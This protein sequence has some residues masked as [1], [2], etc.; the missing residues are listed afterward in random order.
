[1]PNPRSDRSPQ[2]ELSALW[3]TVIGTLKTFLDGHADTE[4]AQSDSDDASNAANVWLESFVRGHATGQDRSALLL[5]SLVR[6][7]VASGRQSARS[8][9]AANLLDRLDGDRRT[10]EDFV[11][12]SRLYEILD[13]SNRKIDAD[14]T[15]L[16]WE[17]AGRL[18][19]GSFAVAQAALLWE[20]QDARQ[21]A[22]CLQTAVA[23]YASFW[24]GREVIVDASQAKL[25]SWSVTGT[26]AWEEAQ[27]LVSQMT[28][29]ETEENDAVAVGRAMVY[30]GLGWLLDALPVPSDADRRQTSVV[31]AYGVRDAALA[32]LQL[33]RC[34]WS[35][36]EGVLF[37]DPVSLGLRLL[38][39]DWRRSF[40]RARTAGIDH[41]PK[42]RSAASGD[43]AWRLV[44]ATIPPLDERP[45]S[46]SLPPGDPRDVPLLAGPS[47]S[48]AAAL[49]LAALANGRP[50]DAGV[51]LTADVQKSGELF[52]VGGLSQ[53]LNGENWVRLRQS[54]PVQTVLVG[55]KNQELGENEV[56]ERD[57]WQTFG[58][59]AGLRVRF[60][61]LLSEVIDEACGRLEAVLTFLRGL[62]HNGLSR[63]LQWSP[64]RLDG[65]PDLL[66]E[67]CRPVQVM[68]EEDWT[69]RASS[70]GLRAHRPRDVDDGYRLPSELGDD[71]RNKSRGLRPLL[72]RSHYRIVLCGEPGEGKTTALWLHVAKR[73]RQLAQ[74]LQ[75]GTLG[76]ESP[77]CRVPLVLPL[78]EV[79]TPDRNEEPKRNTASNPSTE[80]D[81]VA[82]ARE[83]TLGLAYP[84]PH[85]SRKE[86]DAWLAEKCGPGR[87]EFELS[88]DA[89]DELDDSLHISLKHSLASLKHDVPILLTTRRTVAD[90]RLV[91]QGQ[92][93][94]LCAFGPKQI[95]Q[96]VEQYF[97]G[98]QQSAER[99][100]E[101]RG[102]LRDSAGPR[103]LAA[104]PLLLAIFCWLKDRYPTEPLPQ[105]RT[106]LLGL[107]LLALLLRGDE[108]R[109]RGTAR[110]LEPTARTDAKQQILR[111]VAWWYYA[112]GPELIDKAELRRRL[113]Q[114]YRD[115]PSEV[116]GTLPS[117][118]ELLQEYETDGV[119]VRVSRGQYRFV[120]RS[121]HEYCLAGWI[122]QE[123][124]PILQHDRD[125]FIKMI[126]SRADAWHREDWLR[127]RIPESDLPFK[128]LNQHGWNNVW[129]LVGGQLQ[130]GTED[131][132]LDAIWQEHLEAE[133]IGYSRLLLAAH[134]A[135]EAINCRPSPSAIQHCLARPGV[136]RLMHMLIARLNDSA[137]RSYIQLGC[138]EALGAIGDER[139]RD[140]LIARLN[141]LATDPDVGWD[142]TS[143]LGVIGDER[144]RDS[145]IER[146]NN[147]AT[148]LG[149]Q[150]NCTIALGMI[151]DERSR[152]SLIARLNDSATDPYVQLYCAE[153]LGMIG[154][155]LSRDTLIARLN[156]SAM[157]L[158]V[159]RGCAAEL[160]AIGDE[161]SRDTLIARLNDSATDPYAR[162]G[163]AKALGVIG[164]E[165]SRDTLCARL[166]DSVTDPYVRSVCAEALDVI[167]D[168]RL[169]D[170]LIER[171][172][173]SATDLRHRKIQCRVAEALGVIGDERSRDTLI[174]RLNNPATRP[175]VQWGCATGLGAIADEQS[176]DSMVAR[177][178]DSATHE[179]VRSL[180]AHALGAIGDGLSR[181]TLIARLNDS[182]TNPL[183]RANCAVVLGAFED[184]P[185]RKALIAWINDTD[186]G[187]YV[188]AAIE[189]IRRHT[190]WRRL[191]RKVWD[192]P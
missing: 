151:G 128:P 125:A 115:L 87:E 127:V 75:D 178:N 53:K 15:R 31:F 20:G 147:S 118:D 23:G 94:S 26:A 61:K 67:F 71:E 190:G 102:R 29:T 12:A 149:V 101:V 131:W 148:N 166:N 122:A 142:C 145:L 27:E 157:V 51:C 83:A 74:R 93:Y 175:S 133:D 56:H 123:S 112:T 144:S 18:L 111:H 78:G 161:R 159:H 76:L 104:V 137:T 141:D 70:N 107:A 2:P 117:F 160:G 109:G 21:L 30:Y 99:V 1:M 138:A 89:L 24:Q 32:R 66:A 9:I 77:T 42:A 129:P 59:Q 48:G 64:T 86:V 110:K 81:V 179:D 69:A 88:L 121:L 17:Q 44:F 13:I 105:T 52:A 8:P 116:T 136:R 96:Y 50:L 28:A 176:R 41:G 4:V 108:K 155:E 34:P 165:R 173:E 183:V 37:P 58:S 55:W 5:W 135:T 174:A 36:G 39:E 156:D 189:E 106:G 92:A 126:R 171:L 6:Q 172:N 150:G 192:R 153:A 132:L 46:D 146:L 35:S 130:D 167:G 152:D 134:V 103:Q 113:S 7:H 119:L 100:R 140:S 82:R 191:L 84:R 16:A 184:K 49:A 185:T 19:A 120:L 90:P 163:C 72:N 143:A 40:E 11:K 139:S 38:D 14:R 182:T 162:S 97:A 63:H 22:A 79:D 91:P 170:T 124:P 57:L 54:T 180:C 154:D 164:D 45:D 85:P 187:Q 73:C 68:R 43:V 177:L 60:P 62:Q 98:D 181:E 168:E 47:A 10:C 114:H 80:F 65:Q 33:D 186:L 188:L 3:E 158:D 25:A 95:R 169:R